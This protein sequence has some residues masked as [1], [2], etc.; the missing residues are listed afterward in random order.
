MLWNH[1]G[2]H[3]EICGFGLEIGFMKDV[4]EVGGPAGTAGAELVDRL[5]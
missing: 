1:L 5:V 2:V 4:M 3:F